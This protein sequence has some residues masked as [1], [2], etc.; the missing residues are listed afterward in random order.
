MAGPPPQDQA[1]YAQLHSSWLDF[2]R[3]PQTQAA[4]LQFAAS[5]VQPVSRG[6]SAVGQIGR[7]LGDAGAAAGRVGA[8][9]NEAALQQEQMALRERQVSTEERSQ[10]ATQSNEEAQ[11]QLQQQT[12]DQS[13]AQFAKSNS[14]E[15]RKLNE[16]LIPMMKKYGTGGAAGGNVRDKLVAQLFASVQKGAADADLTG[17]AFDQDA[18]WAKGMALIDKIAPEAGHAVPAAPGGAPAAGAPAAPSITK[19]QLLAFGPTQKAAVLADPQLTAEAEALVPGI[20]AQWN[21][22]PAPAPTPATP[23]APVPQGPVD[24]PLTRKQSKLPISPLAPTY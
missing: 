3:H 12:L 9:Q 7:A 6:E 8:A 2:L 15:E 19:E 1:Q 24:E 4:L 17:E 13:A 16:Y 22:T 10:A 23:A 20:T 14:L 5:V 21:G 11:R 18:A